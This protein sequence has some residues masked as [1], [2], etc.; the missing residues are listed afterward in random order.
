MKPTTWTLEVERL[1]AFA[2]D[3]TRQVVTLDA[4]L[5]IKRR[6]DFIEALRAW[7]E[8]LAA[9]VRYRELNMA[10]LDEQIAAE[11]RAGFGEG[12]K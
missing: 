2:H 3:G 11:Q 5:E 10:K 7:T 8:L 12:C 1:V 6:K 4:P 9:E